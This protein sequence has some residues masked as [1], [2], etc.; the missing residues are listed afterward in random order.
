MTHPDLHQPQPSPDRRA[1][2]R[3]PLEAQITATSQENFYCGFTEDLSEGG[4]FV[5]MRPPP[6][7]GEMVHLSVRVGMEPPVTALGQVRWHRTDDSGNACGC[8]VQFVMLDPRAADLLQGMLS[9]SAQAP[10]LVE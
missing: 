10:L 6:P 8:G 1:S 2:T 4:V 7:V 3:F 9:R 5:A